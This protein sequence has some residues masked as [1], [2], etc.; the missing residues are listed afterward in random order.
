M[1]A[2]K[3]GEGVGRVWI[4]MSGVEVGGVQLDGGGICANLVVVACISLEA[5]LV[6]RRRLRESSC[7]GVHL[8]R[9]GIGWAVGFW[10]LLWS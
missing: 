10:V 2:R 5:A 4:C 9:S 3:C 1:T 6:G 7:S 8:L